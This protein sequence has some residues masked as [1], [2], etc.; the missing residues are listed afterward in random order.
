MDGNI[1]TILDLES[2][3]LR[4]TIDAGMNVVGLRV[5]GGAVVVVGEGK[6]VTWSLPVGDYDLNTEMN[7]SDSVR[8]IT[9]DFTS[10][11][12]SPPSAIASVSPDLNY[13]AITKM[14]PQRHATSPDNSYTIVRLCVLYD[15]A[16]GERLA[17][18][19]LHLLLERLSAPWF[20]PDTSEVWFEFE[21]SHGYAIV[22]SGEPGL[23]T[24]VTLNQI[25]PDAS[26]SGGF[27]WESPRGYEVTRGGW[28]LS[29]LSPLGKRLLWLPHSWRS[30]N[31]WIWQGRFLGLFHPSLPEAVILEFYE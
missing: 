10:G 18:V 12:I 8:N 25:G 4:F 26:P 11:F 14:G 9:F 30:E 23:I 1:I 22:D 17:A 15:L 6:V 20:S 27:P 13:L 19:E 31:L 28:V 3:E 2:G 7:T 29:L 16:T 21:N 5:T 24:G